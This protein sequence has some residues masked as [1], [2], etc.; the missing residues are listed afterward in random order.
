[1]DAKKNFYKLIS[2]T[3]SEYEVKEISIICDDL[4]KKAHDVLSKDALYYDLSS[5]FCKSQKLFEEFKL[6]L[7][8]K[9]LTYEV[10]YDHCLKK[11][12]S[13][14]SEFSTQYMFIINV[15]KQLYADEKE[16]KEFR[17]LIGEE[18]YDIYYAIANSII[19]LYIENIKNTID[20]Q[21][22]QEWNAM[23]KLS[24]AIDDGLKLYSISF[25]TVKSDSF[26]IKSN[27][28]I[29]Y[30]CDF[31]KR[32]SRYNPL[33][34][35]REKKILDIKAK[36]NIIINIIALR[37]I[38]VFIKY[39]KLHRTSSTN[40]ILG[41]NN[42]HF[43]LSSSLY[44]ILYRIMKGLN[45]ELV[46]KKKSKTDL[47]DSAKYFIED[48]E[49][50]LHDSIEFFRKRILYVNNDRKDND[51]VGYNDNFGYDDINS[52]PRYK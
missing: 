23:V 48:K 37:I 17:V 50:D 29:S 7:Q 34:D 51:N 52:F 5:L 15:L 42:E 20:F 36:K 26:V 44:R 31:L 41:P 40:F 6:N 21:Y 14:D 25:N 16:G 11:K 1:M 46:E 8:G 9:I 45:I 39:N 32:Y 28:Y 4:E 38:K 12:Q 22:Y 33:T 49:I 10:Y 13:E 19:D 24:K 43:A 2:S 47:H 18:D 3:L 27:S 35:G 30:F